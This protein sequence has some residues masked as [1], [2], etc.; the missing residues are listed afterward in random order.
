MIRSIVV[1][2]LPQ[3]RP[4]NENPSMYNL[5]GKSSFAVDLMDN[6][7]LFNESIVQ[8][9]TLEETNMT[10]FKCLKEKESGELS[11]SLTYLILF[12]WVLGSIM[13]SGIMLLKGLSADLVN[14]PYFSDAMDSS[15][16]FCKSDGPE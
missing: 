3:E 7:N 6:Q 16:R 1:I 12:L 8:D 11:I 2:S 15:G 5:G 4:S 13:M 10:F 9:A 14:F